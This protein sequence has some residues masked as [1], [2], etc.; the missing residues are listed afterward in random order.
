MTIVS[1]AS[2][3]ASASHLGMLTPSRKY[4]TDAN[5]TKPPAS[6]EGRP[7]PSSQ[8]ARSRASSEKRDQTEEEVRVLH[9][10]F[11][12]IQKGLGS[13]DQER[14]LLVEKSQKLEQEKKDLER[15]QRENFKAQKEAADKLRKGK[16]FGKKPMIRS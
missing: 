9:E 7:P 16:Q 3:V 1:P 10:R 11:N 12:Q 5:N 14:A 4:I 8:H 6:T 13:I 15:Q 2:S